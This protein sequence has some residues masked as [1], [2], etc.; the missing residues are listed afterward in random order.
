M[1]ARQARPVGDELTN[2][3]LWLLLALTGLAVVLRLAGTVAAVLTGVDPP[4]G[5]PATGLR[6]LARPGEPGEAL[7]ASDLGP[8]AYWLTVIVL[9]TLT[10]ALGRSIWWVWRS[11]RRRTDNSAD[12]MA[13]TATRADVAKTASRLALTR[14]SRNLRPS[15][16]RARP[17]QVGYLLGH[18]HSRQIWSSVE[19]ST[20]VLGPPRSGKGL[21]LVINAVLDAPG[22]VVATGTRPD[23]LAITMKAR[24][25]IG[26]VA[27]FDPQHLV[28]GVPAGVRWSPVRGCV[29]PLTAM[30]RAKGFAA[31]T[32][33]SKGG[34][35]NG[36][37][38]ENQTA[39]VLQGMLHAAALEGR[40]ARDLFTWSN[41]PAA[42]RDAAAIL[43]SHPDATPGWAQALEARI[44][45]EP[46]NRDST[47][48]GVQQALSCLADPR[49]LDA[50]TPAPGEQF[51]PATFLRENG[52]LYMLA[53]ATGS[54]TCGSLIAAFIEDLAE[55]AKTLAAASPGAR[56][57]PPLLLAL[58]EIGNL[59]PLPSLR[60]L[61]SDG[62]G[63]GITTMPVLQSLAQAR[64]VWGAEE[65]Q[66]IWDAAIV[67][68]V[69][70]GTSSAG[71]LRD[72]SALIGE[73]DEHADTYTTGDHGT[74]SMQRTLR[75]VP[76]MPPERIRTMPFGTGLILLRSAPPIV[77]R[78]R[79]WP[80]R[81]DADD[82]T[83]GKTAIEHMIRR[84]GT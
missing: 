25:K 77:T 55:T 65:A 48:S 16:R 47:W 52:T 76:V 44:N 11:D 63:T 24:E 21:H 22:A 43:A 3:G 54:T 1:N 84:P 36:T 4:D 34:A 7:G 75:R 9:L 2:A 5:G 71:D 13:G 46:R 10:G 17:E 73:R 45:A 35:E 30:I 20:M 49:V 61:M 40:S 62:G 64:A 50:V 37:Y 23:T 12:P 39:I 79:A 68:I 31:G 70:G 74:R 58:D 42:A 6:V 38:W 41:S 60:T 53:T 67:K 14:R 69:L 81:L 33:L 27:V 32:G 51:D 18:A 72:I 15:L 28:Q 83:T 82:L 29:D 59:A 80:D 57:D 56:L 66:A 26:P 19:D 8:V 78:L